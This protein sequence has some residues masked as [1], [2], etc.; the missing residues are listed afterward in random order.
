MR[1]VTLLANLNPHSNV[2]AYKTAWIQDWSV[3]PARSRTSSKCYSKDFETK[4]VDLNESSYSPNDSNSTME[5]QLSHDGDAHQFLSTKKYKD[6]NQNDQPKSDITDDYVCFE[7]RNLTDISEV[8][9][10]DDDESFCSSDD[11]DSDNSEDSSSCE[12]VL[13]ESDANLPDNMFTDKSCQLMCQELVRAKPT[14]QLPP[15]HRRFRAV[16]YIQMELCGENLRTYL[17]YRNAKVLRPTNDHDELDLID[18]EMELN[19]FKQILNGVQYIHSQNL[20]HRDLKPPNILFG[21]DH[22]SVK[23]GDFGLATLH[24]Q[25]KVNDDEKI[26]ELNGFMEE[27]VSE[28][29]EQHTGGLGTSIY[30]APEQQMGVDYDN[31]VDMFSLGIILFE[32]LQPILTEMERVKIIE[33]LKRRILPENFTK[34]WPLLAEIILKLTNSS[35]NERPNSIE[36]LFRMLRTV[37]MFKCDDDVLVNDTP[38]ELKSKEQLIQEVRLLKKE[39][40]NKDRHINELKQQIHNLLVLTNNSSS[41]PT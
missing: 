35:K 24:H 11:D 19:I 3:K 16:L 34:R 17:D 5:A 41:T 29:G 10:Q 25:A 8:L 22:L 33:K 12:M 37:P 32:L 27:V 28:T 20:I 40:Q 2:V 9:E 31:R 1:E 39:N 21:L 15:L 18:I 6:K 26:V 14:Y 38:L 23:I 7:N 36:E 4:I 13:E 30:A